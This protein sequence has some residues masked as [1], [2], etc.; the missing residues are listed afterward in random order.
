MGL[1]GL[2]GPVGLVGLMSP[3]RISIESMDFDPK[4]YGDTSSFDGLVS[5]STST[6]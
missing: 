3:K 6:P 1:V 2:V 4:V 5:F